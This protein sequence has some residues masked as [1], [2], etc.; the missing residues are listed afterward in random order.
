M[1]AKSTRLHI[2]G[3]FH[4][5]NAFSDEL[6]PGKFKSSLGVSLRLDILIGY[7]IPGALDI[8]YARGLSDGG[9]HEWWSL[10]TGTI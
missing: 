8:G 9:I 4:L 3:L 6:D 5:G 7:F 10:V 1:E 2:A